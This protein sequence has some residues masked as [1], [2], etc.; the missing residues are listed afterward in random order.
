MKYR[1]SNAALAAL[2]KSFPAKEGEKAE[3]KNATVDAA[4]L[5]PAGHDM[6]RY[7]GSLTTPPCSEGVKWH[8]MDEPI[9]MSAAQI[10]A[11]KKLFPMNARPVQPLNGRSLQADHAAAAK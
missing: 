4:A 10:Q 3:P 9:Q 5:L 11:F 8:V 1:R 2:W 6:D 7:D